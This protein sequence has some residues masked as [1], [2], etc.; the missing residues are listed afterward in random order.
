[1]FDRMSA[2]LPDNQWMLEAE[3]WFATSLAGLQQ[4]G[5]K[6]VSGPGPDEVLSELSVNWTNDGSPETKA[7]CGSQKIFANGYQNFSVLGLCCILIVGWIVILVSLCLESIAASIQKKVNR[8]QE[9]KIRWIADS[10]FR[11]QRMIYE[12]SGYGGWEGHMDT[13]PVC[14]GGK[15]ET[16]IDLEGGM[17]RLAKK[18]GVEK[19]EEILHQKQGVAFEMQGVSSPT[20]AEISK[21]D[22]RGERAEEN[23]AQRQKITGN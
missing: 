22:S 23:S 14:I 8:G 21:E 16:R 10:D 6:Y 1:M 19:V 13:V 3:S 17:L 12:N 11:V 9:R 18:G 20:V 2:G 5:V 7:L 4:W 15:L